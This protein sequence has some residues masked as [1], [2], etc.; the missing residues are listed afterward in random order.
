MTER[1]HT[2]HF[3]EGG[4]FLH[5]EVQK[6]FDRAM[7]EKFF[8]RA[9][10]YGTR[11]PGKWVMYR[12]ISIPDFCTHIFTAFARAFMARGSLG[13]AST[14]E[15]RAELLRRVLGGMA[16]LLAA[17]AKLGGLSRSPGRLYAARDNL[18][19]FGLALLVGMPDKA[20][21]IFEGLRR[22]IASIA[23]DKLPDQQRRRTTDSN[24]DRM[25]KWLDGWLL[26]WECA[27]YLRDTGRPIEPAS[28]RDFFATGP[29]RIVKAL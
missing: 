28:L 4:R 11:L 26:Q 22:G 7:M 20:V 25:R 6:F 1:Q 24:L 27:L 29:T 23:R 16:R 21:P 18:A 17:E 10:L 14:S 8:E 15:P 5:G 2:V 3:Y 9:V 12:N 13:D 19:S